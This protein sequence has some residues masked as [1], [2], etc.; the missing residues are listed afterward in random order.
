MRIYIAYLILLLLST[1]KLYATECFG[2]KPNIEIAISE[3]DAIF[4]GQVEDIIFLNPFDYLVKM[5]VAKSWKLVKEEYVWLA[6]TINNKE[7][8]FSFVIGYDYLV[9]AYYV[10]SDLLAADKCGRT[11]EWME[12][13]EVE[14]QKLGALIYSNEDS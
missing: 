10:S 5:R 4:H 11:N 3:S 2:N 1:A 6:S 7:S 13:S 8:G 14:K 12:I 9:Y